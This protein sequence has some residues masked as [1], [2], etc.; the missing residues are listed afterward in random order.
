MEVIRLL[1][2]GRIRIISVLKIP[3]TL[4]SLQFK[5]FM[6][7][8]I[9]SF[10]ISNLLLTLELFDSH[11]ELKA[12]IKRLQVNMPCFIL[13]IFCHHRIPLKYKTEELI[14]N[15]QKEDDICANTEKCPAASFKMSSILVMQLNWLS[16][17]VKVK[18]VKMV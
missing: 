5:F 8:Y 16:I 18:P 3:L 14:A 1:V 17:H 4:F 15:E 2:F 10:D 12:M 6:V 13:F 7:S 9:D 11:T